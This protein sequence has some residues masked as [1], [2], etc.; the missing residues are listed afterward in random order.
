[1]WYEVWYLDNWEKMIYWVI[2]PIDKIPKDFLI[3]PTFYQ[4]SKMNK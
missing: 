2:V 1:M 4:A 3:H